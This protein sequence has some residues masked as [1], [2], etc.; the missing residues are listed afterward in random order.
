VFEYLTGKIVLC[1]S[2]VLILDINGIGFKIKVPLSTEISLKLGDEVKIF[3]IVNIREEHIRLFGFKT[4]EEREL[5]A[6]LQSISGIGP[7]LAMAVLSGGSPESLR[8]AILSEDL[9]FFKRIKG[10]GAKTAKR[11]ILELKEAI[12]N[13]KFQMSSYEG[14]AGSLHKDAVSALV[15]LGYNNSLAAEAVESS[16]QKSKDQITLDELICES[17]KELQQS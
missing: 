13:L 10:V 15:A 3:V 17:L 1:N 16:L 7:A 2:G 4:Q 8:E 11:I 5:F 6:K 12:K 14:F 9:A